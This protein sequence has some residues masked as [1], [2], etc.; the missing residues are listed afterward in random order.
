MK[1]LTSATNA[2]IQWELLHRSIRRHDVIISAA[3]AAL[4]VAERKQEARVSE[5][6]RIEASIRGYSFPIASE[7]VQ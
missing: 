7:V 3:R 4:A 5:V 2:E 6:R 1:T